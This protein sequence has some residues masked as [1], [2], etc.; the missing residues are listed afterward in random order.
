MLRF[1]YYVQECPVC[2]RPA[3]VCV[4]HLGQRVVCQHCGGEF[5]ACDLADR[6]HTL[7]HGGNPALCRAERLLDTFTQRLDQQPRYAALSAIPA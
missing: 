3:E 4:K 7:R 2:G 5:I 1:P 6:S